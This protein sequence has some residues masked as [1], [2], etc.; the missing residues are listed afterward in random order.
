MAIGQKYDFRVLAAYQDI[1]EKN[2]MVFDIETTGFSPKNAYIYLI[3][4]KV[5]NVLSSGSGKIIDE[6]QLLAD[7]AVTDEKNI[8]E[9]F[10]NTVSK[11]N[12]SLLIT[13]NGDAFDIPFLKRRCLKYSLSWNEEIE[14]LDIYKKIYPYKQVL[15]LEGRR[16]R[17]IEHFMNIE[18]D[19]IYDGGQLIG[20]YM[21][22]MAKIKI[23]KLA[24]ADKLCEIHD[25]AEKDGKEEAHGLKLCK[26]VLLLHN[27][28][29]VNG[30][31]D[32][33]GVLA[34]TSLFEKRNAI[35][36]LSASF[37]AKSDTI[38]LSCRIT[39]AINRSL[40]LESAAS[41]WSVSVRSDLLEA[42]I[43]LFHGEMKYFYEDYRNYYYLP[44]E[45]MAVHKSIGCF[46]DRTRR[47][48]AKK[49]SCYQRHIGNFIFSYAEK[50]IEIKY[51]KKEYLS[52]E[53]YIELTSND[54]E[55]I[56]NNALCTEERKRY[57]EMIYAFLFKY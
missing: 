41:G 39:Y 21:E 23:K 24:G 43:Q 4:Y 12:I 38:K 3:G 8:I 36:I 50:S 49:S 56:T 7:D 15:K 57:E 10:L 16:L 11:N 27:S 45:D 13:Y 35:N 17:D 6:G 34:F 9:K 20:V 42:S 29:D 25:M 53:Y 19:D 1:G 47:I 18:R 31:A 14:S 37:D 26:D 30:L 46:V 54:L 40:A 5:F 22:Y 32:S 28:D 55:K 52:D 44:N 48:Q 33:I 51:F 2:V